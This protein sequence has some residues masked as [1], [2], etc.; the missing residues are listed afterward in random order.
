MW[1]YIAHSQDLAQN[2]GKW[3]APVSCGGWIFSVF[4]CAPVSLPLSFPQIISLVSVVSC[5]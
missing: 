5:N 4:F 2:G 3:E 1:V